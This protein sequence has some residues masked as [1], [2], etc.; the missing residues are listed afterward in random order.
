MS[1]LR[2]IQR[3]GA[4]FGLEA[5]MFWGSAPDAECQAERYALIKRFREVLT[6]YKE[7]NATKLWRWLRQAYDKWAESDPRPVSATMQLVADVVAL[8]E[9]EKEI[10]A[11][12]EAAQ[13]SKS[14]VGE[15]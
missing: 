13:S 14:S 12:C 11:E 8:R 10:K 7:S 2:S 9:V 5:L 15:A 4:V 6:D 1:K 3:N